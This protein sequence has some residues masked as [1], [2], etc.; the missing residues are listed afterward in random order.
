M[1][2]QNPML[3]TIRLI[4][5]LFVFGAIINPNNLQAQCDPDTQSPNVVCDANVTVQ[6]PDGGSLEFL[7]SDFLEEANDNCDTDLDLQFS[8]D[9]G[10]TYQTGSFTFD[11]S[12]V[13]DQLLILQVIDDAGNSNFCWTEILVQSESICD[14]DDQG[15]ILVCDADVEVSLPTDGDIGIPITDFLDGY[16]D[17]C[18][19]DLDFQ[20]SL[21]DGISFST[22]PVIFNCSN[23]GLDTLL[24]RASD[25]AGNSSMCWVEVYVIYEP[26]VALG[27]NDNIIVALSGDGQATLYLESILEGEDDCTLNHP[28]LAYTLD[29]EPPSTDDFILFDCSDIGPHIVE[30]SAYF[31]PADDAR[32][33]SNIIVEDKLAPFI[34]C[35]DSVFVSL[36]PD[37]YAEI[38]PEILIEE[39]FDNCDPDDLEFNLEIEDIISGPTLILDCSFL[40]EN[41]VLVEAS[42]QEGNTTPCAITLTLSDPGMYCSTVQITGNVFYDNQQD[43]NYDGSESGP[44]NWLVQVKNLS[45]GIT[46]NTYTNTSGAYEIPLYLNDSADP[47]DFEVSLPLATSNILTCGTT[48]TYNLAPGETET[49]AHFPVFLVEDCPLLA[50][51]IATD[52]LRFCAEA[53]Y[54]VHYCNY[55]TLLVEDS[56]LEVTIDENHEFIS[57]TL[58]F[59][60]VDGDTYTFELGD[61]ESGSCG[62]FKIF[63]MTA[64]TGTLGETQCVEAQIYPSVICEEVDPQWSGASIQA[65]ARC[66]G[67]EVVFELENIGNGSTQEELNFLIVEDVVMYMMDSFQVSPAEVFEVRAPANGSTWRLEAEQ[68]PGHPG[69]YQPVAWMEGCGGINTTGLINLFPVNNNDYFRSVFCLETVGSF[70]PND[71]QG[72]PFGFSEDHYIKANQP[73]DY[74]VRF[75]NTGTDTAFKVVI[76]DTL[77]QNLDHASIRP[78]TS[79]H[80]YRFEALG[81]GVVQFIFDDI[82]LPD[83]TTNE[84]A[85]HGFVRFRI[86]QHANLMPGTVIENTAA[87][88][89]DFNEAVITNTT[90]HTIEEDFLPTATF[91][92]SFVGLDIQVAPNPFKSYVNF[93]LGGLESTEISVRLLD[94]AGRQIKVFQFNQ[95]TFDLDLSKLETGTYFYEIYSENKWLASGKMVKS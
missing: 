10:I 1:F 2:L 57:S 31:G 59:S 89:F 70:D 80:P 63:V 4:S 62:S 77:D 84:S 79:S 76:V 45:N 81:N 5:F 27:C 44:E 73:L 53:T 40:G 17:N 65:R 67:D 29:D 11:E 83:S 91:N 33:W 68:E 24:I 3:T 12:D 43:C 38:L 95:N 46:R 49:S 42:D 34:G 51:D 64:C 23:S 14:D 13:G 6:I 35:I 75:Q 36:P 88:Y 66:E 74:L 41:N 60:A 87:I 90:L 37:G 7:A 71:K 94:V 39:I 55:S 15:P 28:T 20:Y 82:E 30:I 25:D 54:N 8:L 19:T 85:S 18:D 32:C 58:P 9:G 93:N 47:T 92:P 72:F 61:L 86:E 78:G 48:Y 16:S 69:S 26:E 52:R 50:V 56:Y 21:D 22:G